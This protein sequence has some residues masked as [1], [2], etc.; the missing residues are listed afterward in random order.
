MRKIL[1]PELNLS[2][3][4]KNRQTMFEYQ[5]PSRFNP[6]LTEWKVL[7]GDNFT[8]KFYK[9]NFIIYT[10]KYYQLDDTDMT[11]IKS[12]PFYWNLCYPL[13]R[14]STIL[15]VHYGFFE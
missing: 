1:D 3:I 12:I 13:Y 14:D 11:N 4:Y 5:I 6:K 9:V 15:I 8:A 10:T 7:G 2:L